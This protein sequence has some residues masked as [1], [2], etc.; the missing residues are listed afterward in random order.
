MISED[1]QKH[2]QRFEFSQ[3]HPS[4]IAGF[5]DGDGCIFIRKNSDGFQSGITITQCRTNILQVIRYHFGGSITT[6]ANRN[7]KKINIMDEQNYYDKHTQR[8]QYNL[9]IRS[10]EFTLLLDYIKNNIVIKNGQI[11]C[12]S[13]FS[14]LI[15]LQNKTEK[16]EILYNKYNKLV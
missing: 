3:P 10:N 13:E 16:K 8:N 7:N 9:I 14:K 12:L 1:N 2:L 6:T 5:I 11:N 4:Y 15:N